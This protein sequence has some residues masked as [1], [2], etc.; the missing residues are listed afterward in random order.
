M[1]RELEVWGGLKHPNIVPLIGYTEDSDLFGPFGALVSKV[2]SCHSKA[3]I[4]LSLIVS[5]SGANMVMLPN[6]SAPTIS[7]HI[8]QNA[9]SWWVNYRIRNSLLTVRSVE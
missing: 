2:R 8:S 1:A 3:T 4:P 9:E 6:T 7:L 5:G